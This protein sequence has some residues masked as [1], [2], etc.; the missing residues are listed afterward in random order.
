[1][2]QTQIVDLKLIAC[3]IDPARAYTLQDRN[4]Q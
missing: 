3:P 1:M 2:M 4:P